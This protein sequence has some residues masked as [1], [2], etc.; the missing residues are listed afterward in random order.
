M[1]MILPPE[2]FTEWLE[3]K[4]LASDRLQDLLALHPTG[5]MEA[6]QVSTHVN[7]PANDDP[8]CVVRVG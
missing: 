3:P 4:P 6:Y 1:P 5:D 7:K 8:E 2:T